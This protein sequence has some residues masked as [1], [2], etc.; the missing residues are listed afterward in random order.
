MSIPLLTRC[1]EIMCARKFLHSEVMNMLIGILCE[2][3]SAVAA[4]EK[5]VRSM[6]VEAKSFGEPT[7]L[8]RPSGLKQHTSA[9]NSSS[10]NLLF[11]WMS[12]NLRWRL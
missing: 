6:I 4:T 3:V 12:S 10:H 5:A 1:L 8:H 7:C 11:E 2:V 9:Y